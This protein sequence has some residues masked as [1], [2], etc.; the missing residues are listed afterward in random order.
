MGTSHVAR[1]AERA[2]RTATRWARAVLLV[3][4]VAVALLGA[5]LGPPAAMLIWAPITGL[6]AVGTAA[7]ARRLFAEEPGERRTVLVSGVVGFL[8]VPF[9]TGLG[10]LGPAGGA[11]LIA[12]LMLGALWVSEVAVDAPDASPAVARRRQ[13]ASVRRALPEMPLEGLVQVWRQAAPQIGPEAAPD[14]RMAAAEL[15]SLLLDELSRRDP[16]G[17]ERWLHAGVDDP[18]RYLFPGDAGRAV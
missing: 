5:L 17:V 3:G 6:F 1:R 11:V 8:V 18:G 2:W 9:T 15:R 16:A 4:A 7:L 12:M 10:V 14:V 13:I